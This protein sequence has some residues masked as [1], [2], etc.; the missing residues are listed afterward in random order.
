MPI[1][2]IEV[3][4][5]VYSKLYAGIFIILIFLAENTSLVVKNW[6][7]LPKIGPRTLNEKAY[8]IA[9]FGLCNRYKANFWYEASHRRGLQSLC[10]NFLNFDFLAQ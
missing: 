4:T 8:R 6:H 3:G 9:A 1:F 7:F 5:R 10:G 2:D